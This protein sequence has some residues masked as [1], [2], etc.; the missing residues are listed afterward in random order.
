MSK[1]SIIL[2]KLSTSEEIITKV[3]DFDP[4]LS[5]NDI[6]LVRPRVLAPMQGQDGSITLTL[7]PWLM[8]A[9]DP[10]TTLETDVVLQVT[11]IIGSVTEPPKALIDAYLSKTSGIDIIKG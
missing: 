6:T 8:G 9:Q 11:A 1:D 7:I 3:K 5:V 10:T 2:L 4:S